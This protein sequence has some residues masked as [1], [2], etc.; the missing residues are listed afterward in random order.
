MFADRRPVAPRSS[1]S[2]AGVPG[3]SSV[4]SI[5]EL[6]GRTGGG[7]SPQDGAA[8]HE[9]VRESR[10][11]DCLEL[12]FAHGVSTLYLAAAL[13]ANGAGRLTSVDNASAREREPSARDLLD[14]AGLAHRVELVY[15]DHSYNW[16]LR[17]ELRRR[18]GAQGIA[19]R[20]DF[21]FV[22]GAHRWVDDGLA[23]SLV[24]RLLAPGGWVLFDDLGWRPP[25]DQA[26]VV[27]EEREL[28]AVHEVFELLVMTH[29]SYGEIRLDD[30]WGWA[31]K[32][33][34]GPVAVRTVVRRDLLASLRPAVRYARERVR[35]ARGR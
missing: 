16:F 2:L 32:S 19:P 30:D 7:T 22:D 3:L 15:E 13:E 35:S 24:D 34:D 31:R 1:A 10:P 11:V 25:A 27:A 29:P 5:R 21:C 14:R 20:F 23:F 28:R 18:L 4:D 12:G 8:L 6:V 9:F 26:G 17:R 33:P